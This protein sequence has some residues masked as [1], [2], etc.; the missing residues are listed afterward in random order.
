M[1]VVGALILILMAS[2]VVNVI[3][4]ILELLAVV[5]GIVLVLGGVAMLMFGRWFLG[6]GP[7]NWG[8]PSST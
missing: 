2:F 7:R 5:V 3:V 4:M 6:R 8:P 1:I